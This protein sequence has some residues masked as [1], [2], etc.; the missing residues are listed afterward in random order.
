MKLREILNKIPKLLP[1]MAMALSTQ[2]FLM[3]REA[4]FERLATASGEKIRILEIMKEKEN[5]VIQSQATNE[6]I[7]S[8]SADA[9]EYFKKA[10]E[11]GNITTAFMKRI[12]DPACGE[13]KTKFSY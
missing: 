5:V 13:K 1:Y 12:A 3:A 7:G 2:N 11:V 10:E 9:S 4:R 6:K 8:L